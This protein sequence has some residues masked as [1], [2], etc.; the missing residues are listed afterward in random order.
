MKQGWEIKKLGE[1]CLSISDGDWIE[2][3]DQSRSGIRLVQT[4][5]IGIGEYR[6][7]SGNARYIAE[8]T[9][10]RLRCTEIVEGDILISRL[11]DPVG[12]ACIMPK[13]DT[14]CI[15]AVDCSILKPNNSLF[16]SSL[17]VYYTQ[18][19]EYLKK[20]LSEC[21]G[22]TRSRISRKRLSDITVIFPKSLSEQ[23]RIVGILD[24]AFDKIDELRQTAEQNRQNAKDLFLS[25]V[26]NEFKIKDGWK[27]LK[28]NSVADVISGYA[29]KSGEFLDKGKFQVIRIG[30]VKQSL[31]RLTESPI[32][33]DSIDASIL[34]KSLLQRGDV[35]ITQTGTKKKRDYGFVALI[36]RD[37]LLLNQRVACVRFNNKAIDPRY[38]LYYS[39]TEMYKNDFFAQEGGAVG[40]GNVGLTTIKE[41]KVPF[42][43]SSEEQNFVVEKLDALSERCRAMEEN[44]KQTA[45]LCT[46]LKQSLLK[47]AFNG[48]L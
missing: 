33:I 15:T 45:I 46:D 28:L 29:F 2:S 38:F 34:C 8:K 36:D 43:S 27:Y 13:M 3:K 40:Q 26:E 21:T 30:N 16:K 24:S 11:P 25:S 20:I 10:S 39:Y 7:K 48:E 9:F 17:L 41:L 4:G 31:L 19:G 22:T 1:V 37:N 47:K 5:N 32:F 6:D 23:E 44:Y 35:V 12:R 42:P 18:S 14:R